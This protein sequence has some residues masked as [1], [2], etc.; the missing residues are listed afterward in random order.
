MFFA[1][2][3]GL[4]QSLDDL[5]QQA[6][7]RRKRLPDSFGEEQAKYTMDAIHEST[8]LGEQLFQCQQ[9][10]YH[11]MKHLDV[12]SHFLP[13]ATTILTWFYYTHAK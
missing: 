13:T 2:G 1:L 4:I 11:S 5:F 7:K 8:S 3:T 10:F 6:Y 12:N 9:G